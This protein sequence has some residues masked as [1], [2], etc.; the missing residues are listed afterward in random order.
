MAGLGRGA[1]DLASTTESP[2]GLRGR[3]D[4]PH[5]AAEVD[6]EESSMLS[7]V[8]SSIGESGAIPALL[9]MTSKP[10]SSATAWSTAEDAVPVGGVDV[11]CHRAIVIAAKLVGDLTSRIGVQ[12]RDRYLEAIGVES[13]GDSPSA[14]LPAARDEGH[15]A[16]LR[17][18]QVH[19]SFLLTRGYSPSRLGFPHVT[20][21]CSSP[22]P[23][24][25]DVHEVKAVALADR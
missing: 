12:V 15:L 16:V 6:R 5:H 13:L 11:H 17:T 2:E 24:S 20:Q 22:R 8:M 9:T 25:P 3:L 7:L 23:R 10:P 4:A 1:D 21:S 19:H 14:A 18:D